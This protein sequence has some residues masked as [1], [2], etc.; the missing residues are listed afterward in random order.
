MVCFLTREVCGAFVEH[1]GQ[2][3]IFEGI[4]QLVGRLDLELGDVDL[5]LGSAAERQAGEVVVGLDG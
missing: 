3:E 1:V 2:A 4:V 5:V